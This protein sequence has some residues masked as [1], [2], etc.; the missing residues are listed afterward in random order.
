MEQNWTVIYYNER[1]KR[2]VLSL[3]AGILADY[4]RLLDLMREFGA[5]LRMPHSRA[6]GGGLFELRPKGREGIGRVFYCTHVGR[7]IVVL[8]S[9]V[10]KTQ[11]TPQNDL[12]TARARLSEVRNG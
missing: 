12:R 4:L 5:D 8:H 1:V 11:E 9:F 3:P 6:M 2:D 7:H 10:K